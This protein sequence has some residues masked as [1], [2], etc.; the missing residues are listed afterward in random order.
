MTDDPIGKIGADASRQLLA[1]SEQI[2]RDLMAAFETAAGRL[3][4]KDAPLDTDI[5]SAIVM[6]AKTRTTVI[7]EI[8]TNDKRVQ[9][10]GG[11]FSRKPHNFDSVRDELGRRLDRI[12]DAR[13]TGDVSE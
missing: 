13:G 11:V 6:L 8:Q 4:A 3:R 9:L 7:Q 12:R 2:L 5:S 1:Q 10:S